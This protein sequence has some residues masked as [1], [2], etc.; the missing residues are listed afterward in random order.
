MKKLSLLVSILAAVSLFAW[1][2]FIGCG[3]F[4]AMDSHEMKS[5]SRPMRYSEADCLSNAGYAGARRA[6]MNNS[7]SAE[8]YRPH[9]GE[10]NPNDEPAAGMFFENYGVNPFVDTDEDRLSTFAI[11]VDTASFTVARNYLDRGNLPPKDSVRPEEFINYFDYGYKAPSASDFSIQIDGAPSRFGKE[12]IHRLLKIGIKTR[13]IVKE[14]RPDAL[15]VFVIDTSGSMNMENRLGLVKKA[16]KILMGQM[17]EGDM[18]GIVEYGSSAR[19]ITEPLPATSEALYEAVDS[20]RSK[21]STNAEAGLDLGY[22][23]VSENFRADCINRVILCS[24][25]VA[26]VGTTKAEELLKKIS[27][28]SKEGMPLS[29]VGFGMGNYND[30][31]MEKLADRGNGNYAYVD[32]IE[33]ARRVFVE[34]LE[35]TLL[36]IAQDVKIQVDFNPEVV[37]SYRLI[38]YENRDVADEDF[39]NDDVDGGEAGPGHSV[40]TLYEIKTHDHASG[41]VATVKMH[42]VEYETGK[43]VDLSRTVNTNDFWKS[44]DEA[45]RGYRLAACAAE[46]AEILRKSYWARGANLEDVLDEL[47]EIQDLFHGDEKY[48]ELRKMVKTAARLAADKDPQMLGKKE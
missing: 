37:R 25:G 27:K 38:G 20:L 34:N 18:I 35:S 3:Y 22:K 39:K 46:F 16:L 48:E 13:E 12:G 42:Y 7:L 17:H 32:K 10:K 41:Q 2:I 26:N 24:D 30:V 6:P 14:N 5:S 43:T 31:F 15:L 29:C 33:E 36:V 44:F 9:G 23:M 21:G 45:D 8:G 11:D 40:T 1:G 19:V 28:Y 4:G 47:D